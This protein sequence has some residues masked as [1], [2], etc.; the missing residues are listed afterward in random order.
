MVLMRPN[1][2]SSVINL[3]P[4]IIVSVFLV[5]ISA[6]AVHGGSGS[7]SEYNV[8]ITDSGKGI[9]EYVV[10]EIAVFTYE[11][12]TSEVSEKPVANVK[13]PED[14]VKFQLNSGHY[15]A[16]Y[17]TECIDEIIE[18]ERFELNADDDILIVFQNSIDL[19]SE[20]FKDSVYC[21]SE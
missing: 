1:K 19:K 8:M 6:I 17:S 11:P 13:D 10:K 5:I 9:I 4:I 14:P 7:S 12:E 3:T 20:E 16:S 18:I 2:W 15:V 21:F